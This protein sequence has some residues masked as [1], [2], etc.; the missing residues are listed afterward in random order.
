MKTWV[1][2]SNKQIVNDIFID[3]I[4]NQLGSSYFCTD[5]Y[6]TKCQKQ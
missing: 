6:K 2:M 5:K 4:A 1:D 3:I